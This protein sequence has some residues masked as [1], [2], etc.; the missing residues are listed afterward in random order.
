[1]S[2]KLQH[3]AY[4]PVTASISQ[5]LKGPLAF[6]TRIISHEKAYSYTWSRRS[7]CMLV[8]RIIA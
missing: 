1:M 3:I 6:V 2:T 8:T 7:L 5:S 4:G